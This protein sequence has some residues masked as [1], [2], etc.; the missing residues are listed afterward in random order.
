L[1]PSACETGFSECGTVRESS[2]CFALHAV[3]HVQ[4]RL[5]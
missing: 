1:N 4:V 2:H 5:D 3:F